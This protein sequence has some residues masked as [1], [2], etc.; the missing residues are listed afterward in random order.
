MSV[1]PNLR[2]ITFPSDHQYVLIDISPEDWLIEV[3]SETEGKVHYSIQNI[4]EVNKTYYE[5]YKNV[6]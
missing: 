3:F 1:N 2:G 6:F 4:L 5:A